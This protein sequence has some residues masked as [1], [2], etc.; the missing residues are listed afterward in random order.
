ADGGDVAEFDLA[1]GLD[2]TLTLL[3]PRLTEIGVHRQYRINPPVVAP[4]REINQVLL[5][6]LD[7]AIR[8]RPSNIWITATTQ[9]AFVQGTLAAEG[10][11]VPHDRA[12]QIF[13]PFFTTRQVGE[14][15]GL[16]L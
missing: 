10:P 6:L 12:S 8:A 11:G 2:A 4:P 7:N 13:D 9:G 14:G 16:G 15:T 3:G 5:N 1:A